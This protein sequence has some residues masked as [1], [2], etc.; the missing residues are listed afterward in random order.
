MNLCNKTTLLT[1][2]THGLGCELAR[3][4]DQESCSLILVYRDESYIDA[5]KSS[6]TRP[7]VAIRCDLSDHA[8]RRE[9]ISKLI[10][11]TKTLDIIVNCAGVGSHSDLSQ[12]TVEEVERVMQ[13]NALSPLELIAGLH[14]LMPVNGLI[15]NIGSVAGEM[16]LPSIG[17]YAAS[18]A[19]LHAFTRS[20]A[21]EG[22]RTLLVVLGPLCGTNFVRSITHPR[23]GQPGWYRRLDVSAETAG[24]EIIRAMKQDRARLVLPRWYPV[25]FF[26]ARICAPLVEILSPRFKRI[27]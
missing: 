26:L 25:I 1:G 20:I 18:K 19:A 13:V 17:L 14:R 24:R 22:V 16:R 23:M 15:V 21:L 6:L 10:S 11:S 4:L 12:M 5:I 27:L 9:L 3:L 2:A 7:I 8:Q